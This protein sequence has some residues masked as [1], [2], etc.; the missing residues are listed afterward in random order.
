VCVCVCI[1]THTHTHTSIT[2]HERPKFASA[3]V[4]TIECKVFGL[5]KP[6]SSILC[7]LHTNSTN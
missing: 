6:C 2:D 5:A 7:K 1:H 4:T 3:R